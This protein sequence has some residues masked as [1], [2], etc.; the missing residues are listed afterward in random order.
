MPHPSNG[1]RRNVM[2]SRQV[3]AAL[4]VWSFI[5]ASALAADGVEAIRQAAKAEIENADTAEIFKKVELVQKYAAALDNLEKTLTASGNLDVIVRLREEREE[6]KKSGNTTSHNDK[7]IV[8]L[9]EKYLKALAAID[10][11]M[12]ATRAKVAAGIT[13]KIREQ[14]TELTKAGKVEDALALRKEG[15]RLLLEFAGG[16]AADA[17]PFED[18]PRVATSSVRKELAPIKI[19][20]ETPPL[21]E[22]PFA[23][24]DRWLE[25]LTVPV[26]KQ[27]IR[28]AVVI[29]DRGKQK[30]P[31]VVVSSGSVWSA[32][33][34]GRIELS[35]GKLVASKCRFDA[36]P[37]G[38]DLASDFY[39][40][41]CLFNKCRFEKVGIW[42]GS[43]QAG[44]F[45]FENCLIKDNFSKTINPVDNGFRIQGSV[46]EDIDLP[47]MSF[48]KRQ[49]A[50]YV[51][52][53]WLRI[54][55][56]RF[57]KCKIP[58]SFLLL[59][60][61][62]IFENCSIIDDSGN[63]EILGEITKPIEIVAYVSGSK[64]KIPALPNNV[65]LIEKP[66]TELKG[67]TIP[68]AA[69]L[70]GLMGN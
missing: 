20:T 1:I 18:D 3:V 53:P 24:K 58:L 30:W 12:Q 43:D 37:M 40:K 7:A 25:S 16:A 35:A 11:E 34:A 45:Y 15:E 57:V 44:K 17:V 14:E 54:I 46:L 63:P 42:Y 50:D 60:R 9:R 69:S 41:N 5:P 62:C 70:S 22:K 32:T 19:P 49:P 8:N 36:V 68:T 27:K 67:V 13:R 47:S 66:D 55:H 65:T 26:A 33:D 4:F 38:A 23:I 59:T 61:D 56:C 21:V 52:N 29:G 64:W 28:E 51:N 2:V 48:K 10:G 39:F 31:I 6:V